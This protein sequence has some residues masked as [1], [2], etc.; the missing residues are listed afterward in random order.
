MKWLPREPPLEACA[1]VAFGE[2][3]KKLRVP[4]SMPCIRTAEMVLLIGDDL[5][6]ADGVVYLGRDPAAPKLLLPTTLR[7]D[8]PLDLFERALLKK[9][10]DAPLAV[11]GDRV[12]SAGHAR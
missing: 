1:V 3:A 8:V 4:K 6:W 7:P 9:F 5:P 2:A 10:E 11:I 12:I